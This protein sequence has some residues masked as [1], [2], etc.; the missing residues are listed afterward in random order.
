[1]L[2]LQNSTNI[3]RHKFHAAFTFKTRQICSGT[4]GRK[5]SSGGLLCHR[6]RWGSLAHSN[7]L[8]IEI[9]S[10]SIWKLCSWEPCLLIGCPAATKA[11]AVAAATATG[12]AAAG[13]GQCW[14]REEGE[15]AAGGRGGAGG[16]SGSTYKE[17][18]AD[19]C[20]DA[21]A[22]F[23][24]VLIKVMTD[25][26]RFTQGR[27]KTG[28]QTSRPWMTETFHLKF[29]EWNCVVYWSTICVRCCC[30]Y[31]NK[32]FNIGGGRKISCQSGKCRKRPPEDGRLSF[33]FLFKLPLHPLTPTASSIVPFE[34]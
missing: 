28:L 2:N 29:V 10:V 20:D 26:A 27:Q 11:A 25:K 5:D 19:D 4:I 32:L 13:G 6:E 8:F 1:M 24:R 18:N 15:E 22:R 7:T 34:I 14:G 17:D 23:D 21:Q 3:F 12:T 9:Q 16:F 30:C 31:V 33:Y